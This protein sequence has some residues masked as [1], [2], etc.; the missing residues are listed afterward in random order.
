MANDAQETSPRTARATPLSRP[1]RNAPTRLFLVIKP[2]ADPVLV[3]AASQRDKQMSANTSDPTEIILLTSPPLS[4]N[5]KNIEQNKNRQRSKK[6]YRHGQ[7]VF[8]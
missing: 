4:R 7:L 8:C 6:S 2:D 3:P 5:Y 1:L